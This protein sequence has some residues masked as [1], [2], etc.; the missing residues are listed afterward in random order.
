MPIKPEN[1]PRYPAD[2]AQIRKRILQR[3]GHRCERCKAP[4]RERIARGAGKDAGTYMTADAELYDAETGELL[5]EQYRHSDYQV[6]HMVT[7]VLTIA[8]LDQV[9]E[10]N[11]DTNLAAL[12]QRCHLQHDRE[13][14]QPKRWLTRHLARGADMFGFEGDQS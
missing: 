9:P 14:S 4:D 5:A 11:D 12:C 3:A 13:P 2:W 6:D 8:H 1:R 7:I 10:H